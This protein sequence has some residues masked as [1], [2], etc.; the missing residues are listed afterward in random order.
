[1]ATESA[2]RVL[3][4]LSSLY[5]NTDRQSNREASRWLEAFQKKVLFL[6]LDND[7]PKALIMYICS[8][9]LGQ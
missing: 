4:A 1:M 8:L 5:S 2:T 3:E 6:Y 9:K 7:R